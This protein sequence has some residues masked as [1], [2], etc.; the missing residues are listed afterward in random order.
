[1]DDEGMTT[2]SRLSCFE[3]RS[4][5]L[6]LLLIMATVVVTASAAVYTVN[7]GPGNVI[8]AAITS[9]GSGD[10]IILNPGTYSENGITIT[11]KD[12]TLRA[13]EGHGPSDTIIDGK[14]AAPRIFT[15]TDA[16]SL[17]I[18][19]LTLRNGRAGNGAPGSEGW[20]SDGG[21][22]GAGGNGG[23][24]SSGGPVTIITSTISDCSAGIGG[25]G[26]DGGLY[27]HGGPGGAAGN[28]GAIYSTNT[29][30]IT[31]S[32][33][34]SSRP[35]PV[36][37]VVMVVVDLL[38]RSPMVAMAVPVAVVAQSMQRGTVTLIS[39]SI[40]DSSAGTGGNAGE[41]DGFGDNGYPGTGGSGGAMYATNSVT[42]TSSTMSSCWPV[43]VVPAL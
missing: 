24:I 30:T 37:M 10:T 29:V 1:M 2:Y 18:E 34:S 40:S 3:W 25:K 21:P 8:Q 11:A 17:A 26:G 39:S 33:I 41:R 23:A 43:M 27:C 15:V 42:L 7:P 22:G 6:V 13:A 4:T 35:V 9:A 12:L 31:S 16:S 28:G 36:A 5:V 19:N 20:A 38:L 32:S 14:S